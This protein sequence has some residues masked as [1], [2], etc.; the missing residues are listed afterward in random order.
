MWTPGRVGLVAW[1]LWESFASLQCQSSVYQKMRVWLSLEVRIGCEDIETHRCW[2]QAR[3]S[4]A[5]HG[6]MAKYKLHKLTHEA[7]EDIKFL[8]SFLSTLRTCVSIHWTR[9]IP[10]K[11]LPQVELMIPSSMCP[12]LRHI[13]HC[14]VMTQLCLCFCH[15]PG[16]ISL[17]L[18]YLSKSQLI[19]GNK[20]YK[21]K[22][23]WSSTWALLSF[24]E[25][26]S[27]TTE[28]DYYFY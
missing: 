18:Q 22:D 21:R 16:T 8:L 20:K 7:L 6:W 5:L 24:W 2:D 12:T 15:L 19:E 14:S 3:S 27:V 28:W 1:V 26:S 23:T 13:P 10:K 11:L 9:L 17:H 25:Q 4:V